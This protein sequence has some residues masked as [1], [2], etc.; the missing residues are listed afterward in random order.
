MNEALLKDWIEA[1]HATAEF[2]QDV[3]GLLAQQDRKVGLFP[4]GPGNHHFRKDRRFKLASIHLPGYSEGLFESDG[5]DVVSAQT[6]T[7]VACR[8]QRSRFVGAILL[9]TRNH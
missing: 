8:L 1:A 2:L 9:F 5:G 6:N 3:D 7:N 4:G